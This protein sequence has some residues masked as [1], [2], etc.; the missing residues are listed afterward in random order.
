MKRPLAIVFVAGIGGALI[1]ALLHATGLLRPIEHGISSMFRS[2]S[3]GGV[4]TEV[5]VY[6]SA[7]GLAVLVAWLT[8]SSLR[9][10]RIGLLVA[11]L[12][13]ELLIAA[14]ICA[15]YGF[16][17]QPV[18]AILGIGLAFVVADRWLAFA[19]RSRTQLARTF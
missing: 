4:A 1:A 15:L 19:Q 10:A 16:T 14:W 6:L 8:A 3:S 9:R 12:G 13:V 5:W 11:A 2:G 18:P 17:F 7:I